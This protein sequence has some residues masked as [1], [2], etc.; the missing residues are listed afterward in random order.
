[1]FVMILGPVAGGLAVT[2]WSLWWD[3]GLYFGQQRHTVVMEWWSVEGQ[4]KGSGV[5]KS[6]DHSRRTATIRFYIYFYCYIIESWI[7]FI[8][9]FK[10]KKNLPVYGNVGIFYFFLI[11][12]SWRNRWNSQASI[13]WWLQKFRCV[14]LCIRASVTHV[15][16][17]LYLWPW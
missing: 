11:N 13:F 4:D 8:I 7:I 9:F 12:C 6:G 17:S 16:G 14:F 2:L 1:M 3:L 10:I 5:G 15:F